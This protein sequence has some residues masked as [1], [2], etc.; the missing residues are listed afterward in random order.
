M[1]L[2]EGVVDILLDSITL[3]RMGR[4]EIGLQLLGVI[5]FSALATVCIMAVFHCLGTW[6]EPRDWLTR[7][8]ITWSKLLQLFRVRLSIARVGQGQG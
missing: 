1:R 8:F 6:E 4:I 7:R 2:H 3:D 5:G